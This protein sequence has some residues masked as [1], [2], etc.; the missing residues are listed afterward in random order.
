MA[1]T[2]VCWLAA[3]PGWAQIATD[4]SVG[5]GMAVS[6]QGPDFTIGA[7]L[8]STV[9]NNL[10]HS[11]SQFNVNSGESATFTGPA[12]IT[13][14]FTRV[15]GGSPSN[16]NGVLRTSGMPNAD[17]YLTNPAG[18]MFGAEAQLDIPGAFVVTSADTVEF[19][20]GGRFAATANTGDSVL[21]AAAPEAFGFLTSNPG[22]LSI[23]GSNL[24][25][26][27][28]QSVSVV[29]GDVATE[30]AT[31]E[32]EAG[33][34][35]LVSVTSPGQVNYNA[36]QP[37][38]DIVV[39]EF[40][41]LGNVTV[42]AGSVIRV[43]GDPAGTV[44]I[45]GGGFSID[46]NSWITADTQ[47]S[48][49][50]PGTAIDLVVSGDTVIH[51]GPGGF[52]E[53]TLQ[54]NS[55][56]EGD[57]GTISVVTGN[58]DVSDDLAQPTLTAG[59]GSF[60]LST[61][62]GADIDVTV[63]Q[64]L[65]VRDIGLIIS[66]TEAPGPTGRVTVRSSDVRAIDGAQLGTISFGPG[67]A[68]A[69]QII[70]EDV[71]VSGEVSIF[72]F[73]FKASLGSFA[74][75]GS[76][77]DAGPVAVTAT[78]LTITDEGEIDSR[79]FGPG[80]ANVITI[81]ADR[82]SISHTSG[83]F[84]G[85]FANALNGGSA[86]VVDLE[87]NNLEMTGGQIQAVTTG[88]GEPGAITIR[89]GQVTMTD[90][91]QIITPT[92]GSGV[93]GEIDLTVDGTLSLSG[94]RTGITSETTSMG[95]AG[96]VTVLAGMLLMSDG[97]L[98]TTNAAGGQGGDAGDLTITADE[99]VLTGSGGGEFSTAL[100]SSSSEVGGQS[101]NILVTADR[102]ELTDR[103]QIGSNVFGPGDGGGITLN[104][105]DLFVS[106]GALVATNTQSTG[107]GGSVVVNAGH[108]TLSGAGQFVDLTD[109]GKSGIVSQAQVGTETA[110]RAGNITV[111]V[112][113]TLEILDGAGIG[114]DASG[115]GQGGNITLN[116]RQIVVS[117]FDPTLRDAL[118]NHP[119]SPGIQSSSASIR[120]RSTAQRIGDEAT[121]NAGQIHLN[122]A[123][124][125]LDN[126]GVIFSGTTT[127]GAGGGITIFADHV[128]IES[129]ASVSAASSNSQIAGPAGSI[130]IQEFDRF[131]LRGGGSVTTAAEVADAGDIT[132]GALPGSP[133][134]VGRSIDVVD[135]LI[136]ASA[137]VDGG[138][139]KLTASHRVR[140]AGST[141]TGRA[142]RDGAAI[143]IDPQFVILQ[144]SVID[145]RAGGVPVS[146]VI[147]PNAIFLTSNSRILTT[148]VSLPP[149]LDLAGSLVPPLVSLSDPSA[150]IE[151]HCAVQFSTDASS[152]TVLGQGGLPISPRGWLPSMAV[153]P[154][155]PSHTEPSGLADPDP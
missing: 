127:P 67:D 74:E 77:G 63:A 133:G 83:E 35:N 62:S 103:S 56:G 59:I 21:T 3:Q 101:G 89:A 126:E 116:A 112:E 114:T 50:H 41:L 82:V 78:N 125:A 17:F 57:A 4:G 153:P 129:G 79:S 28:G 107:D 80:R 124:V 150:Q 34:V 19:T 8:G 20:D 136:S 49:D 140:V 84:T 25:V 33:R 155:G 75:D 9:G 68:G 152:F 132:I 52:L 98:I 145:G 119:Q 47:G 105:G 128:A 15:T 31:I 97:A 32:A 137:G 142:G 99:V 54:A 135:S 40:D 131:T 55:L 106:G 94:Q 154:S 44:T 100:L 143:T 108:V 39:D 30:G 92:Q 96:D 146:V 138:N 95:N 11:F 88:A 93:G 147:D 109:S 24:T 5:P 69:V 76:T 87:T 104:V 86:G 14:V 148:S 151:P 61:G 18:V 1:L 45:R 22:T 6:L 115:R 149:E 7:D 23:Q 10:F 130:V 37:S 12:H 117:G 110:T 42:S 2:S 53:L 65:T 120:S 81:D 66:E 71:L 121:G 122:A 60:A 113:D 73:D 64:T 139:I 72:G 16:I 58:L 134:R 118:A 70:A 26:E 48:T 144:D 141:V 29:G 46:G 13:N 102:L 90:A 51:T 85:I 38:L 123:V 111:N 36:D 43:S 27:P 91:A